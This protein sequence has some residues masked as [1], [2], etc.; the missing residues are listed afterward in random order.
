MS[1]LSFLSMPVA[2]FLSLECYLGFDECVSA[3][4]DGC[5]TMLPWLLVGGVSW[6]WRIALNPN[7]SVV[8]SVTA[9]WFL[10]KP[11]CWFIN[12]LGLFDY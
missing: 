12:N 9:P 3:G 11:F 5:A 8:E 2:T 4:A 1:S 7:V 6:C 10:W